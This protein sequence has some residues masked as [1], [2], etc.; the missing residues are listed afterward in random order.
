MGSHIL[1]IATV[2]SLRV[3]STPFYSFFVE[4]ARTFLERIE[5]HALRCHGIRSDEWSLPLSRQVKATLRALC[6]AVTVL[7]AS[8]TPTVSV[9][10]GSCIGSGYALA[11]GKYR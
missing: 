4:E 7:D 3:D 10:D 1:S 11:M 6:N 8:E 2:L 9:L 5:V